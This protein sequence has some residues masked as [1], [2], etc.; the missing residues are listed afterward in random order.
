[1]IQYSHM[2]SETEQR[3]YV[4]A[5]NEALSR[6]A[7]TLV[8]WQFFLS[9]VVLPNG[10]M[11]LAYDKQQL[12]GS[13]AIYWDEAENQKTGEKVGSTDYIFVRDG[14]RRRGIASSM[15]HKGLEHLIK[16]GLEAAQLEVAASNRQAL[17]IY[18]RLGYILTDESQQFT[19]DLGVKQ[20]YL[21]C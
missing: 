14:W 6:S 13:V 10:I 17:S 20:E 2:D 5:R 11:V 3:S 4:D 16:N 7:T 18:E 21:T 12:I 1:M 19:L 9:H 8:D 15:I